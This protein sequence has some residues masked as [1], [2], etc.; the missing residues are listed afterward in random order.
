MKWAF[1]QSSSKNQTMERVTLSV[2]GTEGRKVYVN[3]IRFNIAHVSHCN[4][5]ARTD[6]GIPAVENLIMKENRTSPVAPLAQRVFHHFIKEEK[7]KKK[8][9]YHILLN[10]V[11][12]S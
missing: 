3:V 5:S 2:L 10:R 6:T 12:G 4:H 1:K 11:T 8:K 7:K 9:P